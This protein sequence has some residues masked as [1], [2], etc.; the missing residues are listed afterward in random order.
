MITTNKV[1][2]RHILVSLKGHTQERP[3]TC[4]VDVKDSND[5]SFNG[6]D[7]VEFSLEEENS[8][9]IFKGTDGSKYKVSLE[10]V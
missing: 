4:W 9:F 10:K 1:N 8:E 3:L 2:P 6:A 7:P 5:P